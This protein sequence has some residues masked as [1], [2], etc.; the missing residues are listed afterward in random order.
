MMRLREP[1][2]VVKVRY[3]SFQARRV[4]RCIA[5]RAAGVQ[6]PPILVP[7]G[8]DRING[9]LVRMGRWLHGFQLKR[10]V[11]QLS[12]QY[13]RLRALRDRLTGGGEVHAR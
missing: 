8:V 3:G 1:E 13:A 11:V 7:D 12:E 6:V 10:H 4:C 9:R 5:C 2:L